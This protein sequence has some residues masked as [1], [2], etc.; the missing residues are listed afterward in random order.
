MLGRVI[1]ERTA[2]AVTTMMEATVDNGTSFQT[3]HDRSGRSYLPDVSVAGKTGTLE[4]K[5]YLFTW[6][7]GFAPSDAPEIAVSV[8]VSNRGDWKVKA[9]QVASDMLRVYFSDKG[10]KGVTDPIAAKNA[11]N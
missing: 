1:E 9:T 2:R 3:F 7:V 4:G 11:R 8:L 10:K 5:G 6:W